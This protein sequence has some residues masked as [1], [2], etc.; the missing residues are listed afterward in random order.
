MI[1]TDITNDETT[2][3]FLEIILSATSDIDIN[4]YH[5]S[6]KECRNRW[7]IYRDKRTT[8]MKHNKYALIVT[9]AVS[10]MHLLGISIKILPKFHQS[11]LQ[12]YTV[13]GPKR[14]VGYN[15]EYL[16]E[17]IHTEILSKI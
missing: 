17:H 13:L 10:Y 9:M 2:R 4:V 1:I 7:R 5:E 3:S 8:T 12:V 15:Y 16:I 11:F 14:F 6:E